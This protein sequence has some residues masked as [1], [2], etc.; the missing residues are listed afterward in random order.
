MGAFF[1]GTMF[2]NIKNN[3]V[4]IQYSPKY[5]AFSEDNFYKQQ[6]EQ[7][8][9]S[10]GYYLSTTPSVEDIL[11]SDYDNFTQKFQGS[12]VCV[13]YQKEKA[14]LHVFN[15][16]LSKK[17]VY[18]YLQG[19][20]FACST[21][22]FALIDYLKK[23]NVALTVSNEGLQQMLQKGTFAG[24]T[25]YVEEVHFLRAYEYIRY[26]NQIVSIECIPYPSPIEN[27]TME[28][29]VDTAYELF[30]KAVTMQMQKNNIHNKKHISSLSGGMDSRAVFLQLQAQGVQNLETY[31]Y[32]QSGSVDETVS[33][34]IAEDYK[35][36]HRFYPLDNGLFVEDRSQIMAQNEGQMY[37][38]GATGMFRCMQ[39]VNLTQ[40]G[41]IYMG[42]GGGE[43]FGDIVKSEHEKPQGNFPKYAY[44]INLDD[45]RACQN[46][47]YTVSHICTCASPFLQEDFFVYLM[48]LPLAIKERRRLYVEIYQKYMYNSYETTAFKGKI[49]AKR[50][51]LQRALHYLR[52]YAFP[53]DRFNMNP[54]SYWW[55]TSP[56]FKQYIQTTYE[57]DM[58]SLQAAGYHTALLE[59]N[60]KSDVLA[61]LRTLTASAILKYIHVGEL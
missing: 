41:L 35:C 6:A 1:R 53:K 34:Q 29:A 43:I 25:T 52:S 49:G 44:A 54:F 55:Q 57:G 22:Y 16:L 37:Y 59:Q 38:C 31:T 20:H 56:C 4:N 24:D 18:Y 47:V 2:V 8:V 60:Y 28:Q 7:T 42:I 9:L 61:K 3:E 23:E 19:N 5:I 36:K 13:A 30:C 21:S 48:R 33:R 50:T 32:A 15:D 40:S 10:E 45:I 14:A 11:Y 58:Q 12:Y 39:G 51:Y 17:Y 27:I 46:S 26:Q